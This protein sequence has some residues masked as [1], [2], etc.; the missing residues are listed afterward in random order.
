MEVNR[1]E[2][3]N[4]RIHI[5]TK[6]SDWHEDYHYPKLKDSNDAEIKGF[7]KQMIYEFN[8]GI[9]DPIQLPRRLVKVER[10]YVIKYKT[11]TRR[12]YMKL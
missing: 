2:T 8:E 12:R 9:N 11:K 7:F 6:D 4:Y 5:R 3:N 1:N 10:E